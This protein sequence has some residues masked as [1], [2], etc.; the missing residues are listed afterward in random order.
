MR[1]IRRFGA[2]G[3]LVAAAVGLTY[4]NST[5][6][7][8]PSPQPAATAAPD[9]GGLLGGILRPR[10]RPTPTPSHSTPSHPYPPPPPTHFPHPSGS[11]S[12][13]ISL[14]NPFPS[15]SEPHPTTPVPTTTHPRP[16]GIIHVIFGGFHPGEPVVYELHSTPIKIG[17]GR[18]S[19]NGSVS[20][21][22][23]LPAGVTGNHHIVAIGLT[24]GHEVS[25]PIT[26]DGGSS[27]HGM[28]GSAVALAGLG[29]VAST[30][31][32]GGV[33]LSRSGRRRGKYTAL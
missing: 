7:A 25:Y 32:V 6:G 11:L 33:A 3:V 13:S 26:I 23:T 17:T 18:A 24:S 28:S 9:N 21:S 10:P 22:V 4:F 30:F 8:A 1:K 14:P 2:A 31:A 20:D 19:S 27:S 16:G 5:A 12:L 29:L 15:H